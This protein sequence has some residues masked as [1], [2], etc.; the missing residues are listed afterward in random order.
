MY[1]LI[2]LQLTYFITAVTAMMIF[3]TIMALLLAMAFA[4]ISDKRPACRRPACV[5]WFR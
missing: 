3:T 5:L 2:R 1:L 4:A